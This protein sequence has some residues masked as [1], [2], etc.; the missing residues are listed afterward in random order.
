MSLR[1]RQAMAKAFANTYGYSSGAAFVLADI[2]REC[3]QAIVAKVELIFT[4][5]I[6]ARRDAA[7]S[8]IDSEIKH[9]FLA[10]EIIG[11]WAGEYGEAKKAAFYRFIETV[12]LCAVNWVLSCYKGRRLP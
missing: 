3:Q 7:L 4:A 10:A 2:A 8:E 11:V 1:H 5:P 9:F 12:E 6:G